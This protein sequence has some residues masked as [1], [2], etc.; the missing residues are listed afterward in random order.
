MTLVELLDLSQQYFL[1]YFWF[2]LDFDYVD[3][4]LPNV[5]LGRVEWLLQIVCPVFEA[6]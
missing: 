6:N 4:E 2:V 5:Y 3:I 1:L